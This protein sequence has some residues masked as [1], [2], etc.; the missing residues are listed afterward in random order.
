MPAIV[1]GALLRS[2]ATGFHA[3]F[4]QGWEQAKPT[5]PEFCTKVE[6]TGHAETHVFDGGL[7]LIREWIGE[8]QRQSI[9]LE[10][11]TVVNKDYEGTIAIPCSAI[12]DD[13][14]GIFKPRIMSLGTAARLQPDQLLANLLE[15]GF[16]T[17]KGYDEVAFF[18]A[19]H[20][21]GVSGT[22]VSNRVSG[23]LSESTFEEAFTKLRKM[24]DYNGN[25]IDVLAIGG[26]VTLIVAANL[27]STGRALVV[28]ENKANG[29]SNPNYNRAKLKVLNRLPDG[30][31]MLGILGAP[32]APF[33]HQVREEPEVVSRDQVDSDSVFNRNEAEYGVQGRWAMAYGMWQLLVGSNGS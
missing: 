19:S 9:K 20:P 25:L 16:T 2:L 32:I 8:R 5:W 22:T 4:L 28:A 1:N 33:I 24:K 13:R 17:G 15:K 14:V 23:A 18:S 27:E 10:G 26:E 12:K 21:T 6:S 7:P 29:A 31:W 30:Y 11:L 3:L